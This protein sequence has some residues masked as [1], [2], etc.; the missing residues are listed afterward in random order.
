M[1]EEKELTVSDIIL[2]PPQS[3]AGPVLRRM[4][5]TF[6]VCLMCRAKLSYSKEDPSHYN[7]H[8]R[9][10]HGCLFN[11]HLLLALNFLNETYFQTLYEEFLS[12]ANQSDLIGAESDEGVE[13][14]DGLQPAKTTFS[15]QMTEGETCNEKFSSSVEHNFDEEEEDDERE[16]EEE[17]ERNKKR[18]QKVQDENG[19][20]SP[21]KKKNKL[22]VL[23]DK[24]SGEN[25]R[26][27]PNKVV[28]IQDKSRY[29]MFSCDQCNFSFDKNIKLKKHKL[30]H[31][32]EKNKVEETVLDEKEQQEIID[33]PQSFDC[34]LCD[35]T[36]DKN[37]KLK[38]HKQ[39]HKVERIKTKMETKLATVEKSPDKSKAQL[40]KNAGAD[41]SLLLESSQSN[42]SDLME[43]ISLENCLPSDAK[44]YKEIRESSDYFRQYPKQIRS[45]SESDKV[46]FNNVAQNFPPG[47]FFRASGKRSCD[48]EYFAPDFTIFRSK[49]A[50]IEYLKCLECYTEK[51]IEMVEFS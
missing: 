20:F 22:D 17:K 31:L 9:Y 29:L 23:P 28:K 10:H 42:S 35:Y 38:K 11:Q 8:L 49:K 21:S 39:Q 27:S 34:D 48:R 26:K 30:K 50:A 19:E 18:K 16:R 14:N 2:S 36:A 12:G 43:H 33:K 37:I 6:I 41:I 47:W 15:M 51:D 32:E 7:N 3:R 46:K 13:D 44:S 25:E 1:E 5:A 40:G 45:G 24:A 4:V